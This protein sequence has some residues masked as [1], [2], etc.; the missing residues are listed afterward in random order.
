MPDDRERR[1]R[2][3][4]LT[5]GATDSALTELASTHLLSE[6]TTGSLLGPF[7]VYMG[8]KRLLFL[9]H[10]LLKLK[11]LIYIILNDNWLSNMHILWG[12]LNILP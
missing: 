4:L 2:C 5:V 6:R 10:P 7:I 9:T 12:T 3:E 1:C 11:S 8:V